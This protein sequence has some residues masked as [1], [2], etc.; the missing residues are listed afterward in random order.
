MLQGWDDHSIRIKAAKLLGCQNLS[1][2][3]GRRLS[4]AE[5]QAEFERNRQLGAATGCW[6][7]GMLVDDDRGTLKA[8]FAAQQ[9][10]QQQQQQEQQQEQQQQQQQEEILR[11]VSGQAEASP[12]EAGEVT[13][14]S[15]GHLQDLQAQQQS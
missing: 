13:A 2:Y 15:V 10:Q 6:K 14:G 5:A 3:Y 11:G 8:R 9:Q 4:R 7:N 12:V 1:W